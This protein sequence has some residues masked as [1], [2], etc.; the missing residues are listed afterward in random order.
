[1]ADQERKGKGIFGGGV[2]VGDNIVKILQEKEKRC[3]EMTQLQRDEKDIFQWELND[4]EKR[5]V[6]DLD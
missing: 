2:L 6:A 4:E 1:M 5:I 3:A